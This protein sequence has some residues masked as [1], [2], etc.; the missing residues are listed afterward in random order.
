M[1]SAGNDEELKCALR[2]AAPQIDFVVRFS[3][4]PRI[5]SL[6]S[7]PD[8]SGKEKGLTGQLSCRSR[9]R[10]KSH[11]GIYLSLFLPTSNHFVKETTAVFTSSKQDR[12]LEI[13][14][15]IL[16]R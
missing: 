14:T 9:M 12:L 3:F 1:K 4:R 5:P 2:D 7:V 13:A 11:N 8:V 15:S 10:G 6:A 16:L